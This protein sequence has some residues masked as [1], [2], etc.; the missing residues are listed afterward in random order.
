M[1]IFSLNHSGVHL[2]TI[3]L[4][5]ENCKLTICIKC[6]P[7]NLVRFY[8]STSNCTLNLNLIHTIEQAISILHNKH[9]SNPIIL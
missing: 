3:V 6:V 9:L 2:G 8:N 4:L 5:H 7:L 1:I